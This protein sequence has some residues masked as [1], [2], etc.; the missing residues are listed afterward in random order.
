[1]KIFISTTTFARY[2]DEPLKLLKDAGIKYDLNPYNRKLKECEIEKIL[3]KNSY[4]G[5][6]AGTEPLTGDV[7]KNAGSLKV[8]SRAGVGLDNL[9]LATAKTLS[10]KVYSTPYVLID[11]VAELTI[12]LIICCLRRVT[13]MN[14][15]IRSKIWKKETGLLFRDKILG[16]IGFG[17]IGKRVARLARTFGTQ[18]IFYDLRSISSKL[19]KQVSLNKLLSDSDIIS[20][21]SSAKNTLIARKEISKMKKGLILVNTSRGSVIDEDSLCRGL[22]SGKVGFAALD[23][24]EQE[25]YSGKLLKLDN[26]IFTPHI[27]SYAKEARIKMEIEAVKNLIN[28]LKIADRGKRR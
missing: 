21:H 26:I 6:I 10:L 19:F 27:G 13:S 23:V 18:I 7:L 15:K 25:P 8:I 5:L 4:N 24:Y 28:G 12:G 16:I 20:I 14:G 9:D 22:R 11:S 3:K 2:S 17:K 1:M